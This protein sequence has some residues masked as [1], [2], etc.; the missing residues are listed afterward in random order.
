MCLGYFFCEATRDIASDEAL[1]YTELSNLSWREF[2]MGSCE[3]S[4]N[5]TNNAES[6]K[7]DTFTLKLQVCP[8][9]NTLKASV[10]SFA[11]GD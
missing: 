4:I 9:A 5:N 6:A 8:D 10:D 3:E 11:P 2:E 7:D 1:C